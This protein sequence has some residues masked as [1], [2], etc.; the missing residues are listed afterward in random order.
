MMMTMM[1]MMMMSFF[2]AKMFCLYITVSIETF[3]LFP[4]KNQLLIKR[5]S[6]NIC[7]V[8]FDVICI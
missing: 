4:S 8:L 5:T 3:I 6:H 7:Q 1:M 2:N